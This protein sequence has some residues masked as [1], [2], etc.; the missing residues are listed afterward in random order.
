M[1]KK[2]KTFA[3][4]VS[5]VPYGKTIEEH[6]VYMKWWRS[7][8]RDDYNKKR[9]AWA[10]SHR[11]R[12]QKQARDSLLRKKYRI[13]QDDYLVMLEKQNYS[14]GICDKK[15]VEKKD[16]IGRNLVSLKVD[17][18]HKTNKVRGLLCNEC[19][20][21]LGHFKDSVSNLKKAILYIDDKALN[22]EDI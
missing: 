8:N 17:H 11:E 21:G 5:K 4:E 20:L 16:K 19:N 2:F 14:C 10:D 6:R 18:D 22:I 3:T 7:I 1:I 12:R 15:L 9:K 13:S